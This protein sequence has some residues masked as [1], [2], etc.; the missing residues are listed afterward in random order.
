MPLLHFTPVQSLLGGLTL[1]AAT[2]GKLLNTGR[3]LGISGTAKGLVNGD[4][5]SWR[6]SFLGGMAAGACLLVTTMPSAL[7]Q[8]PATYSLQRAVAAGLLVGVGSSM[9]NG[10]TSGHGICGVSR[11]SKRSLVYTGTITLA[12]AAAAV[13]SNVAG[14]LQIARQPAT[15]LPPTTPVL[16]LGMALLGSAALLMVGVGWLGNK[17]KARMPAAS[18]SPT[19]K[20]RAQQ[21]QL[22]SLNLAG[23]A[24]AG[25]LFALGLGVSGMTRPS[26]IAGF[27]DVS[28]PAW[29]ASLLFLMGG[30]VVVSLPAFQYTMRCLAASKAGQGSQPCEPSCGKVFQ[31][32]ANNTIDSRLVLGGLLFGAGWGMGGLCPGPALVALVRPSQQLLG[33]CGAMIAGWWLEPQLARLLI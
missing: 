2:A 9:G 21:A 28:S 24:A 16:Q 11:L 15:Y 30:A 4:T 5:Q 32:P 25:A 1:G 3:V 6:I 13:A 20:K 7:E 23:E 19:A 29:D 27:L 8:L 17:L 10:C 22:R 31:L 18:S 33:F 26:K 14:A 12:G